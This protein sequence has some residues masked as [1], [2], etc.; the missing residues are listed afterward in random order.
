MKLTTIDDRVYIF[1]EF[2]SENDMIDINLF[3]NKSLNDDNF[4][5]RGY[6]NNKNFRGN[7]YKD[8]DD[9]D[10]AYYD[11]LESDI[12][13]QEKYYELTFVKEKFD[14]IFCNKIFDILKFL[15]QENISTINDY[16]CISNILVY[17]HNHNMVKHTDNFEK[18]ICTSVLYL[19]EIP[20]NGSGGELV[21]YN[22]ESK[23]IQIYQP[24]FGDLIIFDNFKH[25]MIHSVNTIKNWERKVFRT[26]WEHNK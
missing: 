3:I 16:K 23:P 14:E 5:L 10:R 7:L 2:V 18:R 8:M 17:K 24:K 12:N 1:N 4:W 13:T 21:L 6:N 26:Y 20:E 19:N 22:D 15:Y 25:G 9:N 11:N